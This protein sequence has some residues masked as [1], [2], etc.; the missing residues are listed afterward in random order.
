MVGILAFRWRVRHPVGPRRCFRHDHDISEAPRHK[1]AADGRTT[2]KDVA[3]KGKSRSGE[4][5]A[6]PRL[7]D[8][9]N[10]GS[11]AEIAQRRRPN[12]GNAMEIA[13]RRRAQKATGGT[14]AAQRRPSR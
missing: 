12:G 3:G 5:F 1:P 7:D 14:E 4:G 11:A 9:G 13:Q 8:Q 6:A 2:R 10:G